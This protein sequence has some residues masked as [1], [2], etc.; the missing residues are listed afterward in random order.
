[1]NKLYKLLAF[2]CLVF[3][4]SSISAQAIR[5]A[6]V[7]PDGLIRLDVSSP[8]LASEYVADISNFGFINLAQAQTYFQKYIDRTSGR[9]MD[10]YFDFT[11]QKM[12]IAIDPQNQLL[13]PKSHAQQVTVHNFN[14]VLRMIHLGLL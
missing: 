14:E 10:Y 7:N 13:V 8:D 5:P 2:L 6:F 4:T 12:R 3:V 1:M 9:G 11:N